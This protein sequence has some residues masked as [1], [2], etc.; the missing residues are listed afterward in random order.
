MS[1]ATTKKA[2][3]KKMTIAEAFVETMKIGATNREQIIA[4]IKTLLDTKGIKKTKRGHT[5]TE[6]LLL[7]QFNAMTRDI[8]KQR[9]GWWSTF[10]FVESKTSCKLEPVA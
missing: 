4:N 8:K 7:K 6:E 3:T 10:K 2:T 1:K 9:K 5:I